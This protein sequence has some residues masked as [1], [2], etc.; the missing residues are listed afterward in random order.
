MERARHF[1]SIFNQILRFSTDF[2]K[3]PQKSV[4]KMRSVEAELVR[5]NKQ[6][7]GQT[8]TMTFHATHAQLRKYK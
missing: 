7:D 1:Y 4:K 6:T 5:T 8:D 2:R 3:S